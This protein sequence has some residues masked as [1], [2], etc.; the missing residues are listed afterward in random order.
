MDNF[1]E[2]WSQVSTLL[3]NLI[4]LFMSTKHILLYS[5]FFCCSVSKTQHLLTEDFL[6]SPIDS[7]NNS[8]GWFS[9]SG[10]P[11]FVTKVVSPG[12]DYSGY[13]G[14]GRGNTAMMENY[15]KGD[16]LY[17]RF[18]SP[19]T[20]DEVYFSFLIN[21]DSIAETATQG[22]CVALNPSLGTNINT[23][24]FIRRLSTTSFEFGVAK[25]LATVSYIPATFTLKKTYLA[26]LKYKRIDGMDNDTSSLYVF[27]SG[28]PLTEPSVPH[29]FNVNGADRTDQNFVVLFNNWE[30]FGLTG[31]RVFV[32]GIRVGTSWESSVHALLSSTENKSSTDH[33]GLEIYP[34]PV[35]GKTKLKISANTSDPANIFIVNSSGQVCDFFNV[36]LSNSEVYE[37][38]WDGSGH[39][40]GLYNCIVSVNGISNTKTFTLI[41]D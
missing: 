18:K 25:A 33:V 35:W 1:S 10:D 40:S 34:N 28:V 38:L 4:F 14:S 41:N 13:V 17:H 24:L 21:V 20:S 39:P 23:R 16:A 30:L 19:A 5:I 26:V 27:D 11:R 6:Y 29:A 37:I 32:D 8:G 36:K 22:F 31:M 15:G 7:L 3:S 12:L 2:S 9:Y